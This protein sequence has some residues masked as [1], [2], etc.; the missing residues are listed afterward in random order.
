MG[1]SERP[2]RRALTPDRTLLG[3]VLNER[4]V[5]SIARTTDETSRSRRSALRND[6]VNAM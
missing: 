1:K 6:A 4:A 2:G 5:A 3:E